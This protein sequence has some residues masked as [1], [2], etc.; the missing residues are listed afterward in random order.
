ML[1]FLCS[2]LLL[3]PP[4]T[5]RNPPSEAAIQRQA[6]VDLREEPARRGRYKPPGSKQRVLIEFKGGPYIPEVDR[7][8]RG[9]GFGPY[10]TLFGRTNEAG[11]TIDEPKARFMPFL[12]AEWQFIYL[13]GPLAVGLQL[14]FFRVTGQAPFADPPPGRSIADTVRFGFVPVAIQAVY[15]FEMPADR[16]GVPIVPYAKLGPAFAVWWS[17]G[18]DKKISRNAAGDRG[19]GATWGWQL[20]AGAMLR[21][22]AIEP[23]M[24]RVV[25]NTIGLNHFYLYGEWQISRINNFGVGSAMS[26]GDSTWYAGLAV[27]F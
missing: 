13:A 9:P 8:Y 27:E 1:T 22:D 3:A 18:G 7:N 24:S 26:V 12:G 11:V 5:P 21:L 15:R 2:T 16:W 10:A 17:R 4:T 25:D 19:I 23:R 6:T 20:N 14:G